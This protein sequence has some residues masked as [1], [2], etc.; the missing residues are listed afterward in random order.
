[1]DAVIKT[2]RENSRWV[3]PMGKG[4]LYIRPLLMGSGPI[5]GVAPAPEYTFLVFTSPVGPYFKGGLLRP[6]S[7]YRIG[8]TE[9]LPVGQ[10][11]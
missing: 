8:S 6:L 1:M 10:E 5:L 7:E 3:P 9:R 4:A 2:V 11:E